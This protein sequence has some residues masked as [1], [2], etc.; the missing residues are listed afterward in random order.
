M[1]KDAIHDSV[2]QALIERRQMKLII[3]DIVEEKITKWLTK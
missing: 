3:V 1:A 2:K